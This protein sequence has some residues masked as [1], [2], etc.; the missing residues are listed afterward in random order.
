[1][2]LDGRASIAAATFGITN[3]LEP[4]DARRQIKTH[5]K[6]CMLDFFDRSASSMM[7]M[8]VHCFVL[9]LFFMA[10]AKF[11]VSLPY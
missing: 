10:Q 7:M 6:R 3:Q 11:C 9:I 8:V 2:D 1:M 5:W 4:H